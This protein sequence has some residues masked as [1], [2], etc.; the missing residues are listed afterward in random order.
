M[1]G[2]KVRP[3]I[4]ANINIY[5]QNGTA[6]SL[7]PTFTFLRD[8]VELVPSGTF[9]FKGSHSVET[10]SSLTKTRDGLALIHICTR[11]EDN[12][13]QPTTQ[14]FMQSTKW[15]GKGAAAGTEWNVSC[16]LQ[17]AIKAN[18]SPKKEKAQ[19]GKGIEKWLV[20]TQNR[21]RSWDCDFFRQH[22]WL[23]LMSCRRISWKT[24]ETLTRVQPRAVPQCLSSG[25]ALP[26][27]QRS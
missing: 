4:R 13:S 6:V 8:L 15:G 26:P 7:T 16:R 12:N 14:N 24:L 25:V 20:Q 21:V 5:G 2:E 1:F 19:E 3:F 9:T 18:L 17:V 11:K 10:V 27:L 23:S 22:L